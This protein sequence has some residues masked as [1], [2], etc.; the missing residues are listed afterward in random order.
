M[1]LRNL[2]RRQKWRLRPLKRAVLPLRNLKRAAVALVRKPPSIARTVDYPGDSLVAKRQIY[3][4]GNVSLP[5]Y[6]FETSNEGTRSPRRL[7]PHVLAPTHSTGSG[8]ARR[9]PPGCETDTASACS[10]PAWVFELKNIDFW[11]RYG[12]SV[13]TSDN[14]LLA[15]LSPE[16]W[17]A[18]NHPIFSRFRLPKSRALN[19]KIAIAVTP[20][21]PGNYYHW[22]IDLLPRVCLIRSA[23]GGFASFQHLLIN[24]SQA[25][26]EETSLRAFGVPPEK[27]LYVDSRDHFQIREA[28]ISSMDHFSKVIAPW[29]IE[30]LR[31]VRDSLP[32]Q[33]TARSRRLYVS[34]KRAAVRRV[35]NESELEKILRAAGFTSVELESCSWTDQVAMFSEAEVVLAP[36]GAALANIAFCQRGALLAEINTR[37][38]YRDYYLHLAASAGVRYRFI[39]AQPR[40]PPSSSIRAI[41]NEDMIVDLGTVE[42]LLHAL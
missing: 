20:E 7:P 13:V 29:K 37:T 34:R 21:A 25:H 28:T 31:A 35:I 9:C 15:D 41:E 12:G 22:L 4:A 1:Q 19:G 27:I 23:D 14:F 3:P 6:P 36:H 5:A 26:Y 11:A 30:T 24:G 8:Q 38:G 2:V 40:V 42:D 18:E 16:V 32:N 17:G 10:E 33:P 39:E